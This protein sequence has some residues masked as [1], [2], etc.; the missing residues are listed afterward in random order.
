MGK[1]T[2]K[3]HGGIPNNPLIQ[4]IGCME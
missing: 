3:I 4:V 1:I 2:L